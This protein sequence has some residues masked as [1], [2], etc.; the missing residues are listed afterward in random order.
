MKK[1]TLTIALITLLSAF[2]YNQDNPSLRS[3]DY[4]DKSTEPVLAKNG[5]YVLALCHHTS[6]KKVIFKKGHKIKVWYGE[7][8][9]EKGKI[10][11]I[12][13]NSIYIN[14][15]AFEINKIYKLR[16]KRR[17]ATRTGTILLP[18]GGIITIG[19][20]VM[21]SGDDKDKAIDSSLVDQKDVGV[22]LTA[23]GC[24]LMATGITLLS[25]RKKYDLVKKWELKTEVLVDKD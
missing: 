20:V 17:G 14:G 5:E 8:H 15:F 24:G 9:G 7:N 18:V 11:S 10:D 3:N 1:L 12:S 19:G 4:V 23:L 2:S 22:V 25:L 21:M 13:M 16:C 6:S